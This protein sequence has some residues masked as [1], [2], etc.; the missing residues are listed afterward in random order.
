MNK[1]SIVAASLLTIFASSHVAAANDNTGFYVGGSLGQLKI[2]AK[3]SETGVGLGAYGGYNFN[4]WFGL[5]A[6][7]FVSGDLGDSNEDIGAGTFALTP[8]FTYQ[9]NDTF[10]VYGKV[11]IA[12]M[13]VVSRPD[14]SRN[15]DFTG[16]GWA[17]G[18]GVNASVTENLNIRLGYDVVTGELDSEY[19]NSF[20]NVD[21]DIS[22]FALGMHYQF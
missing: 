17:Y 7:L 2:K 11:G 13:A 12:S 10:A 9:I 15:E 19:S 16:F 6:N 8:K 20:Q 5:E 22:N 21:T 3:G 14:N 4:E 18:V 1:L